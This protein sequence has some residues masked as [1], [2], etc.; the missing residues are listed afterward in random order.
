MACA[1]AGAAGEAGAAGGE[2]MGGLEERG[3][4][5]REETMGM[6]VGERK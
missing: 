3:P 4:A 5:S 1:A 6:G 2:G